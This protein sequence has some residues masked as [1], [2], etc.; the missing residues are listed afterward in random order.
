[1]IIFNFRLKYIGLIG[2]IL[3]ITDT[4]FWKVNGYSNLFFMWGGEDDSLFNRYV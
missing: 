4:D 2:G 1:M 3:S